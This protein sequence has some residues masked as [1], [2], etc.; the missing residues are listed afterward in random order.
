[1]II[2]K[3][4]FVVVILHEMM[5]KLRR[6]YQVPKRYMKKTPPYVTTADS[7]LLY[8][9]AGFCVERILFG[10]VPNLRMMSKETAEKI[11]DVKYWIDNEKDIIGEPK[12]IQSEGPQQSGSIMRSSY[13]SD[14]R[15]TG[16]GLNFN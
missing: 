4:Q 3:A 12:K 1:M 8:S 16:C 13:Q 15:R 5:H 10:E 11:L 2:Q 7:T 6:I 14:H 9:E